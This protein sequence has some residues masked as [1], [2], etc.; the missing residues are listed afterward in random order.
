[1]CWLGMAGRAAVEPGE[2]VRWRTPSER[3]RRKT[4]ATAAA[5]PQL[6]TGDST[7]DSTSLFG[8]SRPIEQTPTAN[9]SGS[10]P[11]GGSA[12]ATGTIQT[13]CPEDK[14]RVARLIAELGTVSTE[15][16]HKVAEL[17]V[18]RRKFE[19]ELSSLTQK[20]QDAIRRNCDLE[21]RLAA[22]ETQLAA[23]REQL[24]TIGSQAGGGGGPDESRWS[25]QSTIEQA[26]RFGP[27]TLRCEPFSTKS[28]EVNHP[29][30][31]TERHDALGNSQ[32]DDTVDMGGI[33][34][35]EWSG[36]KDAPPPPR[37]T[38]TTTAE[39]LSPSLPPDITVHGVRCVLAV[40]SSF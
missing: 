30:S 11:T 27:E 1:M 33:G 28:S 15:K 16:R 22:S 19:A 26:S 34:E 18:T 21:E 13:L 17:A 12:V 2:V 25:A 7:T 35:N 14:A 10:Q 36:G 38:R 23:F 39:R 37:L 6:A 4:P 8:A 31:S 24:S 3:Q 32:L 20:Q 40:C 29:L 5:R 9:G